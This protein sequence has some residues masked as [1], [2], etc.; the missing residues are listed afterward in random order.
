MLVRAEV[1]CWTT[2]VCWLCKEKLLW[3]TAAP[4]TV[5][6]FSVFS[7]PASATRLLQRPLIYG[8]PSPL[9]L[10]AQIQ[11]ATDTPRA[12]QPHRQR[13][14]HNTLQNNMGLF[15]RCILKFDAYSADYISKPLWIKASLAAN[16][17]TL[18]NKRVWPK[19]GVPLF[20]FNSSHFSIVAA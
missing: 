20:Q 14:H 3:L 9:P 5:K 18:S 6:C 2:A 8:S 4:V 13:I 16:L 15:P 19:V 10:C 7:F 11:V 1:H 17:A 12:R